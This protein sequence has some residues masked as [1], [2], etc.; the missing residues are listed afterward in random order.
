MIIITLCLSSELKVLFVRLCY[1][2]RCSSVG[3]DEEDFR[4]LFE[5]FLQ[6]LLLML[7]KPDWPVAE[8]LLTL[9]GKLLV[10][11]II[12]M[13]ATILDKTAENWVCNITNAGRID[14]AINK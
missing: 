7:N 14:I 8:V 11:S 3:K 4:P 13:Y 2:C 9:L 5:N 12:Y 6:D 1:L 10:S